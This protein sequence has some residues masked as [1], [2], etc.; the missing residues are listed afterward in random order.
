MDE[1]TMVRELLPDAPPPAGP[2]VA[3][4]RGRLDAS[5]HG[6]RRPRWPPRPG[7]P[8]AAGHRCCWP[9]A[10]L[11][12]CWHSDRA[13]WRRDARPDA[14]VHAPGLAARP[15]PAS[16]RQYL[17]AMAGTAGQH[18]GDRPVLVLGGHPGQPG[19]DRRGQQGTDRPVAQRRHAS[20]RGPPGRLPVLDRRRG[21]RVE[22]LPG[23]PAW[24]L[25]RRHRRWLHPSRWASSSRPP[26][27]R[28][29]WRR[30]GAAGPGS[31]PGTPASP[32]RS[33]PARGCGPA[34]RPASGRLMQR[35][36]RRSGQAAGD[37][38]GAAARSPASPVIRMEQ[39]APA[40]PTRE[41]PRA[42]CCSTAAVQRHAATRCRPAV[43]AAR[44]PGAGQPAGG[45]WSSPACGTSPGRSAPPCDGLSHPAT[46]RW[47][48]S[49][50]TRPTATCSA[51]T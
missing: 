43:Q 47:I 31:A 24:Q 21:S 23:G 50:S 48:T 14:A 10:R 13:G 35:P 42:I 37:A 29:A 39:L 36:A 4:A 18:P 46:T 45:S 15:D 33:S 25:A 20:Q 44:V 12:R 27:T 11:P 2:V 1:L 49:S 40:G 19:A 28:A 51:T 41:M 26:R 5:M 16:A 6:R 8:S 34:P 30:D 3:A 22:E 7:R 17:L 32:T 9:R 38:R